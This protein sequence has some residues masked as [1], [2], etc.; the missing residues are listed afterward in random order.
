[1]KIEEGFIRDILE[2][3]G[4]ATNDASVRAAR[5]HLLFKYGHSGRLLRDN[6]SSVTGNT[7]TITH[8]IYKRFLDM[9]AKQRDGKPRKRKY[10]IHN[11]IVFGHYNEIAYQ[12]M[13]G[14]TDEVAE[15]IK[16]NFKE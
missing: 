2:A 13:Y 15:K 9:K 10:P 4:K 16:Q 5:K 7:L 1:M 8:P 6:E 11:R 3:Q 14:F 12:L